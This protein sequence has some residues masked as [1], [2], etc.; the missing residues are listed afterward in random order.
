M[1]F[2]PAVVLPALC[3]PVSTDQAAQPPDGGVGCGDQSRV[4]FTADAGQTYVVSLNP[5]RDPNE[6]P[7]TPVPP[8]GEPYHIGFALNPF[9]P[10]EGRA[11]QADAILALPHS[12]SRRS[13]VADSR[14]QKHE[15]PAAGS[16][17]PPVEQKQLAPSCPP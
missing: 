10:F 13:P 2:A 7:P 6:V 12:S 9:G 16:K 8:P 5:F 11:P 4:N 15:H 17:G 1:L 14:G 3:W